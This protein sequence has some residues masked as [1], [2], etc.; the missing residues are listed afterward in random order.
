MCFIIDSKYPNAL[1]SKRNITCYKTLFVT[2][3]KTYKTAIQGTKISKDNILIAKTAPFDI[4]PNIPIANL[5][6]N[7]NR[8]IYYGIHSYKNVQSIDT[9]FAYS[10]I[11]KCIIPKGTEYFKNKTEYV[12]LK[13]KLIVIVSKEDIK[14]FNKK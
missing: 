14:K 6:S 9:T 8:D 5:I 4:T 10:Y 11:A 2:S 12:S 13:V 3:D 7:N 1:R